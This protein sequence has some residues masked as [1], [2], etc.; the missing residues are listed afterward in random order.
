MGTLWAEL[1]ARSPESDTAKRN[2]Q[3]IDQKESG[4]WVRALQQAAQRAPQML[5]TRLVVR[6]DRESDFYELY[7]QKQ[8]LPDNVDL[9]VRSQH[10]R[11]LPDGGRLSARLANAEST[12]TF[13]VKVPRRGQRPERIS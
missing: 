11:C 1:W 6:G 10:D 13:Q 2:E 4:R 5:R 3:S 12:G 7:D 9:P 8:A